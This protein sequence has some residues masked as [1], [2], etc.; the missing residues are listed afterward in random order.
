VKEQLLVLGWHTW[1][2]GKA[3]ALKNGIASG[4]THN[5][6]EFTLH[7]QEFTIKTGNGKHA[8]LSL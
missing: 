2:N 6:Q 1:N 8:D 3:A 4:I 7:L 5:L